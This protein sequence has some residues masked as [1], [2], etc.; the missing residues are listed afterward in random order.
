M[1]ADEQRLPAAARVTFALA[2]H[3]RWFVSSNKKKPGRRSSAAALASISASGGRSAPADTSSPSTSGRSSKASAQ[4]HQQQ[5]FVLPVAIKRGNKR[6]VCVWDGQAISS[7]SA[8][9]LEAGAAGTAAPLRA[10]LSKLADALAESF[11]PN[12]RDVTDDYWHWLPWRLSQ[13]FFS[14]TMTNFSTQSLLMAVGVG[15]KRSLA[16]S[17]AINWML[18]DGLGRL[19]RMTVA[20]QFGQSF[21]ADLKRLRFVTSAVRACVTSCQVCGCWHWLVGG[22]VV[23]ES[24]GLH[25]A[26]LLNSMGPPSHPQP[27]LLPNYYQTNQRTYTP[28]NHRPR[29]HTAPPYWRL[30]CS[31]CPW[32]AS[33]SRPSFPA[34]SS[35]WRPQPTSARPLA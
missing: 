20:T 27:Q 31:R 35:C 10:W 3:K 30:R 15:A 33:S 14:S 28:V 9:A 18:K 8:E 12:P 25:L 19:A 32:R 21:D 6:L 7:V 13:R 29:R 16:A 2:P 1:P 22:A 11:L 4:Q 24:E 34:S 5:P 26:T 23:R 17:A